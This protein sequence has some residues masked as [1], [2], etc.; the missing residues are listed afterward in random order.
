[1]IASIIDTETTGKADDAQ[2]VDLAHMTMP[3]TPG[4]FLRADIAKMQLW[5][6]YFGHSVPMQL[7]AQSTHH[8]LPET[9]KGLPLFKK[10]PFD[11][12]AIGHN[13]DF[14]VAKAL[15]GDVKAICTLA[16]S[17][18]LFPHLDSHTQSAMLYYLA[19]QRGVGLAWAAGLLKEAHSAAED[20]KNC[21]R[22]LKF[23]LMAARSRGYDISSWET[24]Y[25][26]SLEARIPTVMTFGKHAGKAIADVDPGWVEWYAKQPD[27]DKW[28]MLAFK[29]AHLI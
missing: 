28:V 25:Q 2:V 14:D 10:R 27:T 6:S 15:T 1:M 21:A 29:A 18:F 8:I 5:Q 24:V 11:G 26:L 23:L 3:E 22:L 19:E 4:D 9:L 12:Y 17:R 20:V 16:L 13:V 7:G